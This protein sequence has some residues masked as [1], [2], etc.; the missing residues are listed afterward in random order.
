MAWCPQLRAVDGATI[1][2]L[3]LDVKNAAAACAGDFADGHERCSVEVARELCVLDERALVDEPEELFAVDKGVV[4]A[5]HLAGAGE[6]C[7]VWFAGEFRSIGRG[8]QEPELLTR[9]AEPEPVWELGKE[10]LEEGAFA[11]A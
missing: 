6:T 9:H 11:Y 5:V 2:H 8:R 10:A 3:G 7:R 4:F 1:T